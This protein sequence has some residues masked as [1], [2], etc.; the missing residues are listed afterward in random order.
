M[1]QLVVPIGQIDLPAASGLLA[2]RTFQRSTAD[3]AAGAITAHFHTGQFDGGAGVVA[4][5]AW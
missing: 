5:G 2:Q 4:I 1:T 3:E